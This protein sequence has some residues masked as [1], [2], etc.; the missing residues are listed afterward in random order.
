[1]TTQGDVGV[2]PGDI[3]QLFCS[4]HTKMIVANQTPSLL[5]VDNIV[6]KTAFGGYHGICKPFRVFLCVLNDILLLVKSRD[7]GGRC[8]NTIL[9]LVQGSSLRAGI[10]Y[11]WRQEEHTFPPYKIST[12]PL[13]PM[14]AISAPGQA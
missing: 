8:V 3:V 5:W 2:L 9:V 13:A 4:K 11:W 6:N 10:F 1:M 14:T 12:A 7:T